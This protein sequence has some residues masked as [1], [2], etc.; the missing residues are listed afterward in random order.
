MVTEGGGAGSFG[1][2][3]GV[4]FCAG[5]CVAAGGEAQLSCCAEDGAGFTI[6]NAIATNMMKCLARIRP[7]EMLD[8]KQHGLRCW[9]T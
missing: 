8:A 3:G 7:P 5:G 9:R 6:A 1:A 2:A 4:V